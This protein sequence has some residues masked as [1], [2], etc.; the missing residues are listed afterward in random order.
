[1]KNMGIPKVQ[2]ATSKKTDRLNSNG[3]KEIYVP[4]LKSIKIPNTGISNGCIM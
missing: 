2:I 4:E 1:M 3:R